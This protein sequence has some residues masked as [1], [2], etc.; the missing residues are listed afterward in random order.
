MMRVPNTTWS[1]LG[2]LLLASTFYV[3]QAACDEPQ[4]AADRTVDYVIVVTG[5]ELLAGAYPDAH[6]AFLTRT[7]HPLGFHCVWALIVDDRFDEIQQAVRKGLAR[8]DL[9]I[10]TGGLGPTP[11]DV[12]RDALSDLTGVPLRE[13]PELLA[14]MEKRFGAP[15]DQIRANLRKQTQVPERGGYLVNPNGTAPGLVFEAGRQM[16]VALP[17]P[18]RELQPM[19]REVLVPRLT[20]RYGTRAPGHL[21]RLR[22][23][24][25]GESQ[26]AQTIDQHVTI[27]Q[28]ATVASLFEGMRVDFFFTLPG[29]TP[30]ELAQLEEVREQVLD[31]LGE[32]VYATDAT[33]LEEHVVNLLAARGKTIAL[34]EVGS[35]GS[36]VAALGSS[37]AIA[38]VLLGAYVAPDE[39]RLGK[40]LDDS[41]PAPSD[42]TDVPSTALAWVERLAQRSGADLTVAIVSAQAE[43]DARFAEVALRYE[44]QAATKRLSLR[45]TGELARFQLTTQLLDLIRRRLQ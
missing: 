20:E 39:Q 33:T 34:A 9:V 41:V 8:A 13:H 36:L 19:V 6:T 16:I 10:V 2:L 29:A 1:W 30:K 22:F 17:G 5:G 21:L 25:I 24:G 45:G 28:E 26:I 15:R 37:P 12:T 43:G 11:D 4:D 31:Q 38:R 23:V 40:M 27:P 7:L 42:A 32:Y 3:P 35:G 44:G 14:S 18:P